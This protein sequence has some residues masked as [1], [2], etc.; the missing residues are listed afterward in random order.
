MAN[1]NNNHPQNQSGFSLA[2]MVA[3]I[4][5]LAL[6]G[7][8]IGT[9]VNIF[10]RSYSQAQKIGAELSR[11]QAVDRIV[12][13]YFAN[14]VPFPW[15]DEQ[16]ETRYVFQGEDNELYLTALRRTYAESG[17]ALWFIRLYL[18]GEELKC[19]Y[20]PTPILP[21]KA[22]AEHHYETETV[23]SGVRRISFQYAETRD[24]VVEWHDTWVEDD[25]NG[26][27]LAIQITIEWVDGSRERWLRR[28]AGSGGN[29]TYGNREEPSS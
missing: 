27:P 20:A 28:T 8:L 2:E 22:L 26:I 11:N 16:S 9:S 19:D 18:D 10:Y 15:M 24:G 23:A 29:S 12:E 17:S 13:S 1:R 25:H 14:A 5:I 7:L 21:W 4:A 3:A 6:V